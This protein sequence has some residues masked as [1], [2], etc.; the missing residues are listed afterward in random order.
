MGRNWTEGQQAAIEARDADIL[1]AAA[2]GSGKTAVLVERI[3]RRI[4]DEKQPISLDRL[5]V[6]TFTNAAAAE[7]RQR[8]GEAL[9]KKLE[10]EP[11][12]ALLLRQL[13]LLPRATITTIHAF[14]LQMLRANFQ[15][16]NLDPGF[17]LTEDTEDKLMR[18]EALEEVIEEMYEDSVFAEDFLQL[19]EAYMDFKNSKPFYDLIL[20]IYG[21]A[22]SLPNPEAWLLEAAERVRPK[23]NASFDEGAYA[24]P[25]VAAGHD[26]AET[27]LAKYDAMLSLAAYDEGG[28]NLYQFLVEERRAVQTLLEM[29]TYEAFRNQLAALELKRVPPAPKGSHPQH[30]KMILDRRDKMKNAEWKRLR[31]TLFLLEGEEQN[32]ILARLY[33]LMRCLSEVVLRLMRRFDEKKNKKNLLNFNDLE[34]G[35][36]RL[37]MG[38]DGEPTALA[39]ATR[40]RFDEI[41][42]DEYQDTS[43]LQEAIFMAIKPEK[44][45]FLVGDIKQSI[46]RF[47]N[48]DPF[49]F[50]AKRDSYS[51][52]A[53]S[54][55]RKILLSQ[56]FRSRADVLES[57][58]YLFGRV[59]SEK[60]GELVYDEHEMLYPNPQYSVA[61]TNPLPEGSELW[62]T[63]LATEEDED[64]ESRESTEAEAERAAQRIV[65]L[66]Q[67]GYHICGKE[68][69]RPLAYRDICILLRSAKQNAPVFAK[70][71]AAYGIPSY[72]AA[73]DSFLESQEIVVMLSL[74]KIID[75]P[76]QDIP[77]LAVLRS[78]LYA[79][80]PDELAEIRLADR[81]GDFFSALTKR[82][83]TEDALGVRLRGFLEKLTQYREKSR[84]LSIAELVWYVCMQSG[85]YDAQ[86]TLPGGQQRRMNLRLLYTRA[87]AFEAT[88]LKGL[89]SF[90]SF[91]DA[92]QSIGG[93]YDAA[94][95]IGEEQNVVRIM[96]IHKS[97]G[98]EFPVV[99]LCG[100]GRKFNMQ[101]LQKKVL[102][103]SRLGY[104]PKYVD[105]DLKLVYNNA[106]FESVKRAA[107]LEM[108]SEEMRILYVAMTRAREKLIMLASCRGIKQQIEKAALGAGGTTVSG[109]LTSQ[110][111]RYMDWILAALLPHPDAAA[112]RQIGEVDVAVQTAA[113]GHFS[114]HYT[115]AD[116]LYP[117]TQVVEEAAAASP[118]VEPQKPSLLQYTYA[119]EQEGALPAKVTVTEVKRRMQEPEPDSVYL[120]PRPAFLREASGKLTAAEAGTAL[121]TVLE[122]LD[123]QRCQD[124]KS[125]EQ[126]LQESVQS[127]RLTQREAESVSVAQVLRFMQSPIGRRLQTAHNVRREVSFSLLTS[128]EMLLAMPGQVLLQ[129][130]M[131]C[132]LFEDEGIS[133][134]DY[135]TDRGATPEELAERYRVQLDCYAMAAEK[136][137]S[138]KV[139]HKYLYLFHYDR[140]IELP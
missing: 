107:R 89:Y 65:E 20:T 25:I 116:A 87:S 120:Y 49:L 86:A 30:R 35:C 78:Q 105:T 19:T 6:V 18:N 128:A 69:E 109:A 27:M 10:E 31:Q 119:Y 103:H 130:M 8:I 110:A 85:F 55:Q 70:A 135:K 91:I 24:E 39:H 134:L 36:Y 11:D 80:T 63:E 41:L 136:L 121:H 2:A 104:G 53:E 101:D 106:A 68:G 9:T 3:I 77:L 126:Q 117:E 82:A 40:E 71:L 44:G 1:V 47:R 16:L 137:F 12:N 122:G 93:D 17:R 32:D 57:I 92:Y 74:L 140:L 4:T 34:H 127:G 114:V 75:N 131:D 72:S 52:D 115:H 64:G 7:M 94:R 58:N 26:I 45:L 97:K 22:T 13:A 111:E 132:V 98:L 28:E 81:K 139:V 48:T 88:G 113:V 15:L 62:L 112:L 46:Y 38:S 43:P 42:I 138:Q 84:Q 51:M 125:V 102:L 100:M 90:I 73:G 133:I 96:S 95:T 129:G 99:L 56:N 59:M 37:L 21:F 54:A 83:E 118:V 5:L 79:F 67:S 14:C 61:E 124:A 23:P 66:M 60:T 76:H 50:K 29:T 33:P 123:Y 108:L